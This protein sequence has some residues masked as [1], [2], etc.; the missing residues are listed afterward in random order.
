[1]NLAVPGIGVESAVSYLRHAAALEKPQ[2][3]VLGVDFM[4]F[5]LDLRELQAKPEEREPWSAN[6]DYFLSVYPGGAPN[7]YYRWRKWKNRFDKTAS[8][9]AFWNSLG[10]VYYQSSPYSVDLTELGFN[11]MHDYLKMAKAEGYHAIFKQ[12]DIENAKKYSRGAKRIFLPDRRGSREFDTVRG[13]VRFCQ[14]EGIRLVVVIYPYHARLLEIVKDAGLWPEFEDWKRELT[15]ILEQEGGEYPLWDFSGYNSF[16]TEAVPG[17][18]EKSKETR[19]YWEAGHFKKELG[20]LVLA[21]IFG[22]PSAEPGVEHFG[23]I[24]AT[25]N[26]EGHLAAIREQGAGYR[27]AHLGELDEIKPW[28]SAR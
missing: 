7:P 21:R 15:A 11:P 8:L 3:A 5:L 18:K 20:D 4:D 1:L 9:T 19:W 2:W 25:A 6:P 24:L 27:S 22:F 23:A 12:R 28:I 26:I 14:A 10:T 17:A 13:A 16:T